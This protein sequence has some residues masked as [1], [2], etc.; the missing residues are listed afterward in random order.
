VAAGKHGPFNDC[1]VEF[2]SGALPWFTMSLVVV[3]K[4]VYADMRKPRY[5]AVFIIEGACESIIFV[6]K[7]YKSTMACSTFRSIGV[8]SSFFFGITAGGTRLEVLGAAKFCCDCNRVFI[9]LKL[10][11][12][13]KIFAMS[14]AFSCF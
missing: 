2:I 4:F 14:S 8:A 10:S 5:S 13:P 9:M 1:W 7:S 12:V 11:W 3:F 6:F